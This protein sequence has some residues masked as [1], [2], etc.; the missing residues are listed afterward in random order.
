M[1]SPS[2]T[3]WPEADAPADE[4]LDGLLRREGL[5]PRWWSNGPG[6][7]Y[8]AHSHS[9]HKVLYCAQG[10]IRFA[11]DG[12]RTFELVPGDRLDLPPNVSHS[13]VAGPAGVTCVEAA[14][15]A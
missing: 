1:T 10:S 3:P 4:T 7:R 9:Y 15:K 2:V 14:R 5:E 8:G 13:A 12:E 6:D 11:V